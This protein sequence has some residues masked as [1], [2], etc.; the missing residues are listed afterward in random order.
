[1]LMDLHEWSISG[2]TAVA[3]LLTI[4][5]IWFLLRQRRS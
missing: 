5:L 2:P 4:G 3:I 1:L